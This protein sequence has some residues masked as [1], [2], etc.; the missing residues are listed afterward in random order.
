[1]QVSISLGDGELCGSTLTHT[2]GDQVFFDR[3]MSK[4]YLSGVCTIP[5]AIITI[6]ANLNRRNKTRQ[7]F[8]HIFRLEESLILIKRDSA[9]VVQDENLCKFV[10]SERPE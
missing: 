2:L 1:M 8:E 10:Q 5:N 6:N 7:V 9:F 4:L 3:E